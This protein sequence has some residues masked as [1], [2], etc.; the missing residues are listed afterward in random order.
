MH[1]LRA[2]FTPDPFSVAAHPGGPIHVADLRLGAG[3]RGYVAAEPDAIVR[4]SGSAP[5]L[6]F[7]VRATTDVTLVIADPGGRFLCNDDAVPGRTT[8]AVVDVF[9]PRPGQYDVWIGAH[10]A[11]T[12]IDATLFVTS[13]RDQR[14]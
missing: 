13:S 7:F 4:F 6:R 1:P 3:C 11:G 8:N 14:P 5:L 2:Q 10:A 9:A 12:T